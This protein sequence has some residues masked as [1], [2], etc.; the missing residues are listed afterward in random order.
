M[1]P[2]AKPLTRHP[3][4]LRD[5]GHPPEIPFG[6]YFVAYSDE[7]APGELRVTSCF[8][9]EWVVFRDAHGRAGM[10]DPYC[11]HL[12]AHLGFGGK[13]D[14]KLVRCPFHAWGF[15][16][17]G[18]CRDVPYA[19]KMP[20]ILK[21]GPI[22]QSLAL[23]ERNNILWAW[24]HPGA[25][26][27]LWE[28]DEIPEAGSDL[29]TGYEKFEFEIDTSV[30]DIIENS[31]DY[32]HLKYVHG[33]ASPLCGTT[34]QEGILRRVDIGVEVPVMD[35]QG[36][37]EACRYRIEMMQKGPGQHTVRY[38]RETELLMLFLVTPVTNER[39]ILRLAFTHRRYPQASD[40]YQAVKD[41]MR[42]KI[43]AHG[44]LH[45]VH[46]DIPIWN[47]KIYRRQPVLCDGDGPIMQYR[48]WFKQFYAGGS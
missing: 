2:S 8:W 4:L 20:P 7:L 22:L 27:P 45:G 18:Y 10:I 46:A 19:T 13:V 14:G 21:K 29:W 26:A 24:Y 17:G 32:A 25:V 47:H 16:A 40:E 5:K 28:V 6:W 41:F 15:D 31:I 3:R 1:D 9:Q 44:G 33:H 38:R 37:S 35:R 12:G 36:K 48:A 23:V 43:G 30:Q 42:E 11:P 39:T 34:L